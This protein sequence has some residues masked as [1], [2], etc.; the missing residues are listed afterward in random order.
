LL[1]I[2]RRTIEDSV[3]TF[4]EAEELVRWVDEHPAIAGVWPVPVLSRRLRAMVEDGT[5]DHR[6]SAEVLG[7]LRDLVGQDDT[8]F[9]A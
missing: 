2:A 5:L 4:G 9:N 7:T 6:E 1:R 8:P 3:V